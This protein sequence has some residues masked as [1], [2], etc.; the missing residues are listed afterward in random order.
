MTV[1]NGMREQRSD[2]QGRDGL[3]GIISKVIETLNIERTGLPGYETNG[4]Q[5]LRVRR[6]AVVT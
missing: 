3:V 1:W 4:I 5:P 6:G 2:D